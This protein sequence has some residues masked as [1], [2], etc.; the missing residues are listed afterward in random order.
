[1]PTEDTA[2]ATLALLSKTSQK[3]EKVNTTQR[4]VCHIHMRQT[5]VPTVPGISNKGV[6]VMH[7][8]PVLWILLL[9][10]DKAINKG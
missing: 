9:S 7:A 4:V 6:N 10:G 5:N 3:E 8:S 1:M 2:L